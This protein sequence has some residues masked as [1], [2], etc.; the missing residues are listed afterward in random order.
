ML[1]QRETRNSR[2]MDPFGP[3]V[4]LRL[5]PVE[6][7]VPD[8]KNNN[9]KNRSFREG[10]TNEN[11]QSPTRPEQQPQGGASDRIEQPLREQSRNPDQDLSE[12]NRIR[13]NR[14]P[15]TG[16]SPSTKQQQS[17]PLLPDGQV[18]TPKVDIS[19]PNSPRNFEV[20]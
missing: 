14:Q 16:H 19:P 18:E 20:R 7:S 13:P 11:L 12:P 9:I 15:A 4:D 5:N 3:P 6:Q 10:W 8:L 17:I 1:D 2:D